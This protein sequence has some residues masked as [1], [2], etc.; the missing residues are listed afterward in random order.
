[1]RRHRRAPSRR[2]LLLECAAT[3]RCSTV[4][5]TR[6]STASTGTAASCSLLRT[7]RRARH[8][9]LPSQGVPRHASVQAQA[10]ARRRLLPRPEEAQAPR[11]DPRRR[12]GP[13]PAVP[14]WRL[15]RGGAPPEHAGVPRSGIARHLAAPFAAP[16]TAGLVRVGPHGGGAR[17][18]HGTRRMAGRWRRMK[19]TTGKCGMALAA[20]G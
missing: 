8:S 13:S 6:S 10:A 5:R 11:H 15:R 2:S 16:T 9:S 20:A 7:R 19:M 4:A 18:G 12:A 17:V 14:G 1:V 3:P